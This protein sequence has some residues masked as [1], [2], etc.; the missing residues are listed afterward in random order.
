MMCCVIV[1]KCTDIL[2]ESIIGR[3]DTNL[4]YHHI[5]FQYFPVLLEIIQQGLE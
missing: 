1:R 3:Y 4:F 2:Y 5:F